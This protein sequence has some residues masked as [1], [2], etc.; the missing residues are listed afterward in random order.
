MKT[1]RCGKKGSAFFDTIMVEKAGTFMEGN[2]ADVRCPDCGAPAKY[3]I[4][5]QEYLCAYCGGKVGVSEAVAQKQGFRTIQQ[6]KIRKG[7]EQYHFMKV[8]CTGC[9]ASVIFAEGEAMSECVF[10]GTALVRKQY[11]VSEDLPEMVIPFRITEEEAR[12]CV[13][14][15]CNE[16][17]LKSEARHIRKKAD[18]LK[19]F[20][21]PYELVRGPVSCSVSRKDGYRTYHCRGYVD[22]VFINCSKQLD[23]LLL[24]GME[25]FELDELEP[26]DFS[27]VAGQRVKTGDI[28]GKTLDERI[29]REVSADYAPVVRKT[30]ETNAVDVVTDT[31][32][33]L[34]LP[35]LLPVYY[36]RT[37]ETLC[38]VNGQ[39]GKVSV[40]AEKASHVYFVPWWI[41]AVLAALL[42]SGIACT[43]FRLFGMDH[44]TGLLITGLL[45]IT[46]LIIALAAYSDTVKN[47]FRMETSRKIFTSSGGPLERDGDV[48][49]RGKKEMMKEVIPPVFFEELEGRETPVALTFSSPLRVLE[50]ALLA[51]GVLFL[52]VIIALFL[53]GFDFERLELG[54]SAVWFCI[55]VPVVPVYIIKFAHIELYERPWIYLLD[56][57][58]KRKR[59]R[60]KIQVGDIRE[61]IMA[62]LKALL[63]PPVSLAVWLG[64]ISFC[65]ICYLTAFGF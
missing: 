19:G 48:L 63:V 10:C 39:T 29:S 53:N 37:P 49:V 33:V 50:T 12:T 17:K 13:L 31:N 35:V 21:L 16:N 41:K 22:N 60:S 55:M 59:Y 26:F 46:V 25:P 18:E 40:R 38:A 51:L 65:V 44:M 14:D 15:W 5:R 42:I 8:E 58:G 2:I 36:I 11:L 3:N 34:R 7:A 56:E 47:S 9:G 54:G 28:D 23:N 43:S 45:G 27:Y 57:N 52:P 1:T 61:I 20:Y 6:T 62:V 30:L 4:I 32:L 24:D 64:I